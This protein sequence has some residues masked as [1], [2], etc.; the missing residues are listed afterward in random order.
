MSD[1]AEVLADKPL[2]RS[3]RNIEYKCTACGK[4]VERDALHVKRVQF[5][6]MG[7]HGRVIV[8]RVLK[9]LCHEC[10]TTDPD[11][12]RPP[13]SASPGMADTKLARRS[14]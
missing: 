10:M 9:W 13:L 7:Q 14:A 2:G 12:Q 1:I 11:F 3:N 8:T 5:R 6:E 4:E